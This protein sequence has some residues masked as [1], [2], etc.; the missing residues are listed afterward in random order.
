[1]ITLSPDQDQAL[2]TL[3]SA[4]KCGERTLVLAGPAGTGKTTLVRRFL[5][6]VGRP[7]T[8]IAPTGKAAARLTQ[9]TGRP[10]KTVHSLLYGRV[11]ED[12]DGDPVFSN[13]RAVTRDQRGVVVCDE[14]SMMG[15]KVTEELERHLPDGVQILYVG[16]REQLQ[17]VRDTWGPDFDDPTAILTKVHR[18]A[19]E[20][21][22][23]RLATFV[24]K[25]YPWRVLEPFG[26]YT[27]NSSRKG[28]ENAARWLMQARLKNA[29]A[30]LL[31]YTNDTRRALNRMVR[32]M[33][34]RRGPIC[35][36][37]SLV[38]RRN[39]FGAEIMNG[40]VVVVEDFKVVMKSDDPFAEASEMVE[41]ST[42]VKMR[43]LTDS[44]KRRTVYTSPPLLAEGGDRDQWQDAMDQVTCDPKLVMQA[45]YGECLTV[46][47]SQGSEWDHVGVVVDDAFE[48]V[49]RR[50][51]DEHRRLL[52]TAVTRA[53]KRLVVFRVL[54]KED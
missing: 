13:P 46:H 16:D 47:S 23:I 35:V 28:L 54:P 43:V 32:E 10:A 4:L 34:G 48:G 27:C 17:P 38:C 9:V 21:A 12:E 15:K 20:S 36:G 11:F 19:S 18:Q 37:D 24:R 1:M 5:D 42:M 50:S 49:S 53:A 14:A 39:C 7:V 30:T 3:F 22:I 52:Y 25:G 51:E 40:E 44:G 8:M 29:S 41:A 6:D 26:N 2:S 31:T 33:L 45:E